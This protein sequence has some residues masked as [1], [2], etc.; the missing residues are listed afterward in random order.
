MMAALLDIEDK[1]KFHIYKNNVVF[2]RTITLGE[3]WM[4]FY[5]KNLSLNLDT[6]FLALV[7]VEGQLSKV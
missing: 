4:F 5:Y 6:F 7:S 2:I 1:N 3:I